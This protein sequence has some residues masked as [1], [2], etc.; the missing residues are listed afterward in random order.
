MHA[1]NNVI[2]ELADC[3]VCTLV[4]STPTNMDSMFCKCCS[5][6][7]KD[8]VLEFGLDLGQTGHHWPATHVKSQVCGCAFQID[9][10]V[11]SWLWLV[12]QL[13]LSLSSFNSFHPLRPRGR[14]WGGR[15]TWTHGNNGGGARGGE[16]GR[17]EQFPL[18]FPPHSPPPPLFSARPSF[19]GSPRMNSYELL[20]E[21]DFNQRIRPIVLHL[22]DNLALFVGLAHVLR[23]HS[24]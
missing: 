6:H 21:C 9:S 2:G 18:L 5:D 8:V 12:V 20:T 24:S 10:T 1:E 14:S 13:L 11:V 3:C 15:E 17:K 22:G 4:M 7:W 19:P 23:W 16:T